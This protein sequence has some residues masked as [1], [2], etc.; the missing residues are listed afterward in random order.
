M[1][2][3]RY[4]LFWLTRILLFLFSS[5]CS[6]THGNTHG[7]CLCFKYVK[8]MFQCKTGL[9]L[10]FKVDGTEAITFVYLK[11]LDMNKFLLTAA[12]L[13]AVGLT[14]CDRPTV[15]MP[16]T[17]VVVP[18][19]PIVVPGPA[20]PAGATGSQGAEGMK[21]ETGKTGEGGTTAVIVVP[22][23]TPPAK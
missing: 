1:H 6:L 20:G 15:V 7:M 3:F 12:V 17:P 10:G 14:A 2:K 9:V 22:A 19:A 11:G 18:A 16:T 5:L 4:L 13:T 21:G 8:Y 23:E